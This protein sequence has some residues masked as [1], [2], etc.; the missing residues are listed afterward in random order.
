MKCACGCGKDAGVYVGSKPHLGQV[1]G[2]PK[3]FIHGHNKGH[4]N[5]E[6][7]FWNLVDKGGPIHPTLGTPCWVWLG[8]KTCEGYGDFGYKAEYY[9]A[10]RLAWF[11]TYG[12][13]P[14]PC[15]CHKCDNP[16]CCNPDHVFEGTKS[17][18]GKDM[19]TKGRANPPVGEAHYKTTLTTNKVRQIRK[20]WQTKPFTQ[21]T[22]AK[23]FGVG[24]TTIN[25]IIKRRNWKAVKP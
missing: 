3:V 9:L 14:E 12:K 6:Q 8:R 20:M 16:P 23:I 4:V 2:T 21:G 11:F 18:N 17:D 5:T 10:H 24:R 25:S 15:G 13:F 22:L 1:K 7:D 19:H